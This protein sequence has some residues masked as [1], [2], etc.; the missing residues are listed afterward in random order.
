MLPFL[1]H[2]RRLEVNAL[3]IQPT[4]W[5]GLNCKG[6]YV[7]EHHGDEGT[8]HTPLNEQVKLFH[9]F[10][11]GR[12]A[13]ANQI[14]ISIDNLPQL[15]TAVDDPADRMLR[16]WWEIM[17]YLQ[18]DLR[19]KSDRPQVHMTLHNDVVWREYCRIN[20][21]EPLVWARHPDV[22][23]FSNIIS[24][25]FLKVVAKQ[26]HINYNHLIPG[27]VTSFN[28]DKYVDRMT[29]IGQIVD[30][31]YL[32]AHKSPI[33]A[34][35]SELVRLGDSQRMSSDLRYIRTMLERLPRDVRNK[36]N[37]DGC[38]KDV[39]KARKTGFGC[40]S[41]VSRFQVWPD[42]SVSGCPYAF[43]GNTGRGERAE[44]IMANIR[45]ARETYDFRERCHLPAVIDSVTR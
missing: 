35:R 14:S 31:I 38:I 5:C 6:C 27:N 24:L 42:G 21:V 18:K 30:S 39:E 10:F 43:S 41:N 23:S 25:D 17:T 45:Q 44:D 3:F 22:I 13:W 7:K 20:D 15:T 9:E 40:S 34:D 11:V 36:T 8:Y 29:E 32:V 19:E 33:G 12:T 1:T 4:R 26:T 16:Y 2:G 28:I 37:V